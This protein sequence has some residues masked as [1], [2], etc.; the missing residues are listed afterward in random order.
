MEATLISQG[1]DLMLFGMGT[2]FGFLTL[3]PVVDVPG[4]QIRKTSGD[5]LPVPHIE[6]AILVNT[7]EFLNRWT[8]GQFMATPHRVL[9]PSIDRYS[10]AF[11]YCLT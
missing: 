5:W 6:G 2:V 4:L 1:F 10:I 11:F 9:P 7:G 8:N 3:L